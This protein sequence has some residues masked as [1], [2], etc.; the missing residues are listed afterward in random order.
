MDEKKWNPRASR[1][2]RIAP[3]VAFNAAAEH[4]AN[5]TPEG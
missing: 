1:A 5:A 4:G 2:T 3:M